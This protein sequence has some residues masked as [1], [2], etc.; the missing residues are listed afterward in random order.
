M[1]V[2]LGRQDRSERKDYTGGQIFL[3]FFFAEHRDLLA[4]PLPD[5]IGLCQK[6]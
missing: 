5:P 6:L 4:S 3:D 1:W 2:V